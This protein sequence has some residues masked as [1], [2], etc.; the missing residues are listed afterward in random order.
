MVLRVSSKTLASALLASTKCLYNSSSI[1]IKNYISKQEQ[2]KIDEDKE[3][4]C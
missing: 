1:S 3:D 2:K 4:E